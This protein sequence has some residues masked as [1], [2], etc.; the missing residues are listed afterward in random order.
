VSKLRTVTQ[1]MQHNSR[2]DGRHDE[3]STC[4]SAAVMAAGGAASG[5]FCTNRILLG[6]P[7]LSASSSST[8]FPSS[9]CFLLGAAASSPSSRPAKKGL[10][11]KR[12]LGRGGSAR[13]ALGRSGSFELFAFVLGD[14]GACARCHMSHVTSPQRSVG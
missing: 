5:K 2:A 1:K 6:S 4:F 11:E 8:G 7:S 12:A 13:T 9:A 14:V 10:Q 3:A